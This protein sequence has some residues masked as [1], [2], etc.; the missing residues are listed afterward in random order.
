MA[1]YDVTNYIALQTDDLASI[2]RAKTASTVVFP[3]NTT[4]L[5]NQSIPYSRPTIILESDIVATMDGYPSNGDQ[6]L[7]FGPAIQ[8]QY[9]LGI[10]A[11]ITTNNGNTLAFSNNGVDF[12]GLGMSIFSGTLSSYSSYFVSYNGRIWITGGSGASH[13]MGY[14][15]D[16]RT[17]IGLGLGIFSGHAKSAAWNGTLWVASGT[18]TNSLAYSYDG[19]NWIGLGTS[20]L[21]NASQAGDVVWNGRVFLAGAMLTATGSG[22]FAAY[23]FDGLSW[24]SLN[25]SSFP[26]VFTNTL[27]TWCLVWDGLFWRMGGGSGTTTHNYWYTSDPTGATGWTGGGYIGTAGGHMYAIAFNGKTY[28]SSGNTS[29]WIGYS[30]DGRT[31]VTRTGIICNNQGRQ[32]IWDGV[33]Y[34]STG[35]G[36]TPFIGYSLNGID[37]SL[38]NTNTLGGGGFGLRYGA[39]RQHSINYQRNLTIAVGI[40]THTIAYSL[41]GINWT[42]LGTTIF[43]TGGFGAPTYNGRLWVA[44]GQGTNTLAFSKDGIS[45]KG[46]GT[47]IF[48]AIGFAVAWN[49]SLWVAAGRGTNTLA[50]SY[51]GMTWLTSSTSNTIETGGGGLTVIWTGSLWVAGGGNPPNGNVIAYSTDGINWTG[52]S[53]TVLNFT[54]A[55]TI[56]TLATNGEIIVGGGDATGILYSYNAKTW[57]SLGSGVMGTPRGAAWNGTMFVMVGT[58]TNNSA[59]SYDGLTW[60]G[61]TGFGGT[62]L[63]VC[64]NGTMWVGVGQNSIQ[65]SYNGRTWVAATNPFTTLVYGV[66]SNYQVSPKAFIQHPTLAGGFSTGGIGNT[67]AYS[68]DGINW[69][70]LGNNIFTTSCR[71]AVWNGKIWV[72]C[73]QGGNTLAYSY[74]GYNW[75][76]LGATIFSAQAF[77]ACYNGSIWVAVGQGTNSIAYSNN[78]ISWTGVSNSTQ[79][80]TS[81]GFGI[82]WNGVVFLATGTSGNSMATSTN[83]ITWAG[84]SSTTTYASVGANFATSNGR[85]WVATIN[86]SV[87]MIYTT[88][89]T[90]QTGWT[91]VTSPFSSAG[92]SVCWNGYIWVAGGSGTVNTLARSDNGTT[93]TGLGITRF[94]THVYDVCWNG[95][96]FVAVGTN[97]GTVGFLGHSPDGITWY[98]SSTPIFPTYALGVSSNSGVGAFIAPSAMVLNNNGISGNGIAKSQTLEIVSS[99]PYYQTG[100]DNM[101]VTVRQSFMYNSLYTTSIYNAT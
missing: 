67:M 97:G 20:M 43:T 32:T 4:T 62:G 77:S 68:P 24:T 10:N 31:W 27:F 49:G 7:T 89:R 54:A 70:N 6:V 1:N 33:K 47:S 39:N 53:Y 21:T 41:N 59:Y 98:S 44:G 75:I 52:V 51:D 14:S 25:T 79:I 90:A 38:S 63:S 16:G 82:A 92:I 17:W 46:L 40:G 94:P 45:W 76:G 83:G 57:I 35:T 5:L 95:T 72:A 34:V 69:T 42:G 12:Y 64:W 28:I 50:Y 3:S 37:W 48:T 55:N 85:L 65:Y 61:G 15:Y 101:S 74:D 30:F 26:G 19:I 23:S 29:G 84:V 11:G 78:G 71:R 88:D 18:G 2:L 86:S 58:V 87:G 99:D 66:G 73:G 13:N 80:F 81:F 93:W 96:R 100:F 22:I 8:N 60:V 91:T 9:I 36:G 56:R